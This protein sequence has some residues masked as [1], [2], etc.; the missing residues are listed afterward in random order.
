MQKSCE[1]VSI[2]TISAFMLYCLLIF[3]LLPLRYEYNKTMPIQ[4]RAFQFNYAI[5]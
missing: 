2:M 1:V 4:K 5:L 3:T